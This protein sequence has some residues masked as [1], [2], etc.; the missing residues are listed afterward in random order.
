M[1]Q[2]NNE[3]C[4]YYAPVILSSRRKGDY[5]FS[6]NSIGNENLHRYLTSSRKKRKYLD[7]TILKS[8]DCVPKLHPDHECWIVP[9]SNRC[10][11]V[12]FRNYSLFTKMFGGLSKDKK[13]NHYGA[14][15]TIIANFI[16]DNVSSPFFFFF[17][18]LFV[19][20]FWFARV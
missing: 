8:K 7:A 19:L 4:I 20:A 10:M 2:I 6:I 14:I 5:G 9:K 15:Q 13:S 11:C 16:V 1:E 12:D 17:V 18:C 3:K